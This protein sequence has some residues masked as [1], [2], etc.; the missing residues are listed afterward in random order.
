MGIGVLRSFIRFRTASHGLPV[1]EGRYRRLPRDLRVCNK[2][3]SGSVDGEYHVVFE[4]FSLEFVRRKYSHLFGSHAS[5][6][7]QFIWQNDS[8]SVMRFIKGVM[9]YMLSES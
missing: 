9:E 2:Y 8:L 6:M 7:Q 4:C 3:D 5:T 1:V